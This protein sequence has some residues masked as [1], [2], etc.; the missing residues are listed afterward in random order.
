MGVDDFLPVDMHHKHE[1]WFYWTHMA[2]LDYE[3]MG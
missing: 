3:G 2:I 1:H